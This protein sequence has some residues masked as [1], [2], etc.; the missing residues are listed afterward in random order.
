M[1]FIAAN[2][3]IN[4]INSQSELLWTTQEKGKTFNDDNEADHLDD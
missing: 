2:L 1:N 3:L 4:T